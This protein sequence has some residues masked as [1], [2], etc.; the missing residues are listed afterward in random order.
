MHL[1]AT[2]MPASAPAN[3]ASDCLYHCNS[4]R[5]PDSAGGKTTSYVSPL[6]NLNLSSPTK[7][8]ELLLFHPPRLLHT[9]LLPWPQE[10]AFWV[11]SCPFLLPF[12]F[13][14]PRRYIHKHTCMHAPVCNTITTMGVR[15]TVQQKQIQLYP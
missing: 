1:N 4:R 12:Q 2:S 8:S 5:H 11:I 15:I 10:E 13:D 3:Q 14:L 6:Q 9:A 7:S